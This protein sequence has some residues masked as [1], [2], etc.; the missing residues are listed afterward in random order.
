MKTLEDCN[1]IKEV[2][3]LVESQNTAFDKAKIAGGYAF[4]AAN[5]QRDEAGGFVTHK[6]IETQLEFLTNAGC[7]FDE[8]YAIFFAGRHDADW[9]AAGMV[10]EMIE[11]DKTN[12]LVD[13]ESWRDGLSQWPMWSEDLAFTL[14][15]FLEAIKEA[16]E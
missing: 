6:A 3:E 16:L 9:H 8:E 5:D 14:D 7:L 15:D 13:P 10:E 4:D 11:D 2:A 1:T 12:F